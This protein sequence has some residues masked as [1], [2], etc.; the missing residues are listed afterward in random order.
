MSEFLT[1]IIKIYNFTRLRCQ[2]RLILINYSI[3]IIYHPA[4]LNIISSRRFGHTISRSMRS[5]S[6]GYVIILF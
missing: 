6:A 4:T 1:N 3:N 5:I 2:I